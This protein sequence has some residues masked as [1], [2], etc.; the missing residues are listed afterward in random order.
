MF[1][2]VIENIRL[3]QVVIDGV[4]DKMTIDIFLW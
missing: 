3:L 4:R 2:S 1:E